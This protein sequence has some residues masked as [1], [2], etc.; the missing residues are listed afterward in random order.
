MEKNE[1][2]K[3]PLMSNPGE[4]ACMSSEQTIRCLFKTVRVR[5]KVKKELPC[6]P[7]VS[8]KRRSVSRKMS[9]FRRVS[10]VFQKVQEHRR[11]SKSISVSS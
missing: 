7:I 8:H 4:L 11:T 6:C 3:K 1:Q 2:L 5:C 10:D 9:C